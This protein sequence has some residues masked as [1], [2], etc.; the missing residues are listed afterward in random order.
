MASDALSVLDHHGIDSAH[1]VGF[2]LGGMVA[3]EIAI[4]SPQRVRSLAIGST[5]AGGPGV[6]A[7]TAAELV[8]ELRRTAGR[9]PG[10]VA[11]DALAALRQGWAASTHDA[12]G[13][14]ARIA[15]PTLVLHGDGDELVPAANAVWLARCIPAADLRLVRGAGHLLILESPTARRALREWLDDHQDAEPASGATPAEQLTDLAFAPARV[16]WSQTL[17]ARRLLRDV[18]R[19]L[20]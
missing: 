17:P 13:R 2:S 9:I 8:S 18:V 15:A 6:K 12:T 3:Q 11:V 7:P 14:L 20:R 19:L 16:A 5:S 10:R 1:V 4:R